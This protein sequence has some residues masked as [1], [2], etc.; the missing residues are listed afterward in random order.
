MVK[1]A[2]IGAG[3]VGGVR[4]TAVWLQPTQRWQCTCGLI[5]THVYDTSFTLNNYSYEKHL[6][7]AASS[8]SSTALAVASASSSTER[9]D[10]VL[11][12]HDG[13]DRPEVP[14]DRGCGPGYQ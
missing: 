11:A 14:R 7:P 2:C 13:H 1:I 3:Y 12:A 8:P 6:M 10:V 4:S 5:N 9:H